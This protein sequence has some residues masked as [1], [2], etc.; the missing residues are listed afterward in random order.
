MMRKF[1]GGL[2]LLS[3]S[4]ALAALPP[5]WERAREIGMVVADV[6]VY[7]ALQGRPIEVV[8]YMGAG[9]EGDQSFETYEVRAEGCVVEVHLDFLPAPE[10]VQGAAPLFQPRVAK[11]DGCARPWLSALGRAVVTQSLTTDP[12]VR[13]AIEADGRVRIS[14]GIGGP[15]VLN[16]GEV[17][18]A[19]D[20]QSFVVETQRGQPVKAALVEL[21]EQI[22]AGGYQVV[23]ET[24][25]SIDSLELRWTITPLT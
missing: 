15:I 8:T 10:G 18:L 16:G 19:L 11:A 25:P 14:A 9:K 22:E 5:G 12:A 7:D 24:L 13:V 21:R 23:E 20:G 4:A 2:V 17:G 1:M 6:A 3:S